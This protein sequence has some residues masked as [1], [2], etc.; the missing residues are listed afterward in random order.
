MRLS[1]FIWFIV[2]IITVVYT[3]T[4]VTI[5]IQN[6]HHI[7]AETYQSWRKAYVIKQSKNRSFVNTSNQRSHPVAL[8][9]GQGYG[10]YITA[11]AGQHGWAKSQDFDQLLNYY[12]A[13]RDY[14]GKNQQKQTYL[15]KWRQ[16]QKDG[17]WISN[18]NS[19]TDGDLF[20][21]MALH[22]AAKVWPKKANYYRGLERH[23]TN[24]ILKYE[25]NPQTKTL[26]VGDWAT[27]K[28]KYYRLIR[29]SDVAPTFFDNFYQLSH[30]Q[31]WR[32]VK[33]G[34]LHRLADLSAQHKTGLVPDFAW[35][36]A[37]SAKPVKPWTVSSKNDG[38]YSS[39]ACRVPMML[40]ASKDSLAQQ[41]LTRMM[42]FFS[43]RMHI[44]AG[45]TLSGEQLNHYQS[46]SFRAPIFTAVSLNRNHGYDNLF[47]SQKPIFSKPLPKNNYYD[48]TLT[49]IAAMEGIN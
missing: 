15:M 11:M 21:A 33:N 26:T 20:I 24:D 1:K 22:Q 17:R 46:D 23:L 6:P 47:D 16:Y 38:N 37:D 5:R 8:S 30:D 42:K 12:L 19:A 7:Q 10:L 44:T 14:V 27:N 4:L 9:E 13:H 35:V 39:N 41:T 18:E 31:R 2:A 49:T 43:H 34:M 3:A 25:Y 48:A 28:S 40:A 36:T 45:Y 32:S 29:T